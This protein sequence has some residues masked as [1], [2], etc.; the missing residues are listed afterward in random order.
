MSLR[1]GIES[2]L[3]ENDLLDASGKVKPM[4][5]EQAEGLRKYINSNWNN[6]R[7]GIIGRLKDKID[8]D[9]TRVAGTDI[10]ESARGIRTKMAN[11]L[12]DPVGVSK[13]MDYDPKTPIN[14]ATPFPKI[15]NAVEST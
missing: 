4:T 6:E 14:R 3:K 9:V 7:S 10:Y 12:E 8:N 11:L 2:H 5:V 1:R 15:P 13:I